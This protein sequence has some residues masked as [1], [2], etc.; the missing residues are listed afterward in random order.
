MVIEKMTLR[1]KGTGHSG[2][3]DMMLQCVL[4]AFDCCCGGDTST[5]LQITSK[6][7]VQLLSWRTAAECT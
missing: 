4:C 7:R 3:F 6:V 5:T 1:Q 2:R